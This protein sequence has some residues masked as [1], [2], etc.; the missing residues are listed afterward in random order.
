MEKSMYWRIFLGAYVLFCS[1]SSPALAQMNSIAGYN[2]TRTNPKILNQIIDNYNAANPSLAQ[3]MRHLPASNGMN[4]GIRYRFPYVAA[5]FVWSTRT[6]RARDQVISTDRTAYQN[7][8]SLRNQVFSLGG[9]IHYGGLGIGGTFDINRIQVRK[10]RSTDATKEILLTNNSLTNHIYLI[11]DI[12]VNTGLSISIRPYVQIP[13]KKVN[14]HAVEKKFN[15]DIAIVT[16][17]D[18]YN[19]RFFNYGISFSFVNGSKYD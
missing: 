9:D 10:E 3:P 13:S 2:Y 8:I 14:L 11:F 6:A 18:A 17:P 4:L 1:L 16:S 7:I 5:E 15:P 12:P 19:Q